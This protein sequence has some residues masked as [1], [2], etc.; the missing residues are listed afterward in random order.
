VVSRPA[1]CTFGDNKG[2]CRHAYR[3]SQLYGSLLCSLLFTHK[4]CRRQWD[5]IGPSWA[6][7]HLVSLIGRITLCSLPLL[8]TWAS[9]ANDKRHTICHT[10]SNINWKFYN[11][12]IQIQISFKIGSFL[13]VYCLQVYANK[14]NIAVYYFHCNSGVDFSQISKLCIP[15]ENLLI[16]PYQTCK[17]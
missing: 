4:E 12:F 16:C 9:R 13:L 15:A 2:C 7:R 14:G 3:R 5:R 1:T 17:K 8:N 10:I 11:I 6:Q